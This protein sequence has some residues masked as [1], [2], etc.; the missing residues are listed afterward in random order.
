MKVSEV[1]QNFQPLLKIEAEAQISE[2]VSQV[3]KVDAY[4]CKDYEENAECKEVRLY[5]FTEL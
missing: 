2:D 3:M 4:E 5:S 1:G